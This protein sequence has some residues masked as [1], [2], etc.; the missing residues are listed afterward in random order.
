MTYSPQIKSKTIISVI[1]SIIVFVLVSILSYVL[2]PLSPFNIA[3]N[4]LDITL[5]SFMIGLV[6][7]NGFL[8]NRCIFH[9]TL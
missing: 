3:T 5:I 9:K 4:K 7:A 2:I 1:N 6:A 8:M